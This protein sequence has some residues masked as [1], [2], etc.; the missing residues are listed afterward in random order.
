LAKKLL[1]NYLSFEISWKGDKLMTFEKWKEYISRETFLLN[2]ER[3]N[4]L[5]KLY[6]I[7]GDD[8]EDE[9]LTSPQ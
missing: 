9:E 4:I 2:E 6:E 3:P 1:Q 7:F 5:S 8:F